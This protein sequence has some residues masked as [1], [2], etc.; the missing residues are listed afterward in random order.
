MKPIN[1]VHQYAHMLFGAVV[2]LF[3]VMYVPRFWLLGL[4]AVAV[5][6]GVREL[7]DVFG[8]KTQADDVLGAVLDFVFY[9]AGAVA[10]TMIL[11]L[12]DKI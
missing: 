3:T 6:G 1:W 8:S 2:L 5:F 7:D 11:K 12:T 4:I 9:V 10:T